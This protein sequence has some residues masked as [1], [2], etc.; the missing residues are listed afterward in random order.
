MRDRNDQLVS[1]AA[2]G[3]SAIA[4]HPIVRPPTTIIWANRIDF[5]GTKWRRKV[6]D[7]A[8]K[9]GFCTSTMQPIGEHEEPDRVNAVL[10]G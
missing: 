8:H 3:S 5:S 1:R 7:C 6:Y 9:V 4:S 10:I 2:A